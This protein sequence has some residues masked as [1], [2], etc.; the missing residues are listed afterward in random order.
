MNLGRVRRPR[1]AAIG[2]NHHQIESIAHLAGELREARS[3]REYL[4]RY[5]PSETDVLVTIGLGDD[6]PAGVGRAPIELPNGVNIMSLGDPHHFFWQNPE[7]REDRY[8][9]T[10][11]IANLRD[12]NTERELR[13][14]DE[15]SAPYEQLAPQLAS[16]LKLSP[17]PPFT[18]K[19][20][21]PV[22]SD[23]LVN[24]TT[25]KPIAIRV[26][27]PP[28]RNDNATDCVRPIALLLPRSA[29]LPAWFRSFLVDIHQIDPSR[30]PNPP[31][32]LGNPEDWYTPRERKLAERIDV[33]E[34][35]LTSLRGELDQLNSELAEAIDE[36]DDRIRRVI[37][38][39]G[40]NL[41]NAVEEILSGLGF[42]VR[43]MDSESEVG[44]AKREDLRL[45][46]ESD[47]NWTA[48][49]EVKS[50][51]G[52]TK[53]NDSRQ[54][55]EHRDRFIAEEGRPP[56]KTLWVTN[57]HREIDPSSR[58]AADS[59]VADSAANV[60]A[61]HVMTTDLYKQWAL[62]A[63][64]KLEASAVV[65]GIQNASPGIW[66]PGIQSQ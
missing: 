37:W 65:E 18:I 44:K 13:V 25:G 50:Y 23:T 49:V 38:T 7:A 12:Q 3:L 16:Q 52:G 20:S 31:P 1:V 21:E 4:E 24:T 28:R 60:A 33:V 26:Q 6:L 58:P 46:V 40:D 48:I 62:V 36:E 2:L 61:V 34:S 41:V 64:G 57:P 56:D 27:L 55:R 39:Q 54:I 15:C 19:I 17:D 22:P 8:E 63:N 66:A 42:G 32:Q 14:S 10:Y 35:K 51:S 11:I 9:S 47:P 59:N 5:D 29:D 53:T 43:N 30:V 45:Y